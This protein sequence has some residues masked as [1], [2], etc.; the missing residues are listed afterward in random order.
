MVLALAVNL[1]LLS[2]HHA[3]AEASW[4]DRVNEHRADA[5]LAPVSVNT[6]WTAGCVEHS[7][8]MVKNDY[9]GHSQSIDN[10]W[11]TPAGSA[12][13]G[14][15]NVLV[16]SARFADASAIDLWMSGPFHALGMIDP[17]LGSAA[18]GSYYEPI[19][20]WKYGATLNVLDGRGT[21]PAGVTFPVMWPSGGSVVDLYA[22]T[23]IERPDPLA[24]TGWSAPSGLPIVVQFGTGAKTPVVTASSF[25]ENGIAKQHAVFTEAT[26]SNP[27]ASEQSRG[28]SV[29]NS[30]DAVVLVPRSP[31]Q[32]AKTYSVS[33]S[34]D[35][36]TYSWSFATPGALA[37]GADYDL[38]A[39]QSRYETAVEASKHAFPSGASSVIIATG[40]SWPDALGASALAGVRNA[41]ILLVGKTLSPA[42]LAE[43]RRLGA[44]SATII[45]G[46][47]AVSSE[48]EIALRAELGPLAVTR[49]AG[50]SR[51]A[52]SRRIAERVYVEAGVTFDGTAFVASGE[53]FPDALAAS[54][55]AYANGWPIYLAENGAVRD[56]T[57]DEMQYAGVTNV[58]ILGGERA[59]GGAAQTKL[60]GVFGASNVSRL[61]GTSRYETAS[62]IAAYGVNAGGL[63]WSS[64][65]IATGEAF[66]DAL[67]GGVM[68]G[69]RGSVLLLNPRRRVDTNT[70]TMLRSQ[71]SG[72]SGLC[73]L[74]GDA[75]MDL[76]VREELVYATR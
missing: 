56:I 60:K 47:K 63:S 72:I 51:F 21:V 6:A 18:F 62:A 54:P 30:R 50:M 3:A 53:S 19:G 4:I 7:R 52:T 2:P 37:P 66:P 29:L 14:R 11:Y 10:P 40:S 22:Y 49:I 69:K 73:F 35:G 26:Y 41:P 71:A 24:H 43:I 57:I 59:V 64:P 61:S 67:S 38:V 20:K 28:R 45:G 15:S 1:V 17:A 58:V 42:V 76:A 12:A 9:I 32:P 55:A 23:G 25:K 36:K 13:A 33:L 48:V 8:Y 70:E 31:L 44:T 46:E 34:V 39:G 74:G 75:A 16:H 68:Q 65:A 5:G 27:D